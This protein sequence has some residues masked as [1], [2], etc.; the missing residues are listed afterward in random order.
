M[1]DLRPDDTQNSQRSESDERA[2]LPP[3]LLPIHDRLSGDGARWRWRAPTGAG[4]GDWA[5]ATLAEAPEE[6]PQLQLRE[7]RLGT[8]DADRST[9]HLSHGPKG[10]MRDMHTTSRMRGYLGAAAAV[11]V[12]GLIALLLTQGLAHRGTGANG[13]A[14]D[15]TATVP[16][17]PGP[18]GTPGSQPPS[19]YVQ[20]DQLPVVAAN[21]SSVVYKIAGGA[22][23]RSS[24]G[25]KTYGSAALPR[26]D[27]SQIDSMSIAV[28]PLDAN[29][30][31]VTLGGQK[32][33]QGCAPP[34]NPYPALA[35]HGGVMA[36][37]YVPCAEQYMSVDGGH[38]WTQPKLPT[39][40]VIGGLNM[41]RSV[42]GAYGD[43]SYVFQTQ[44]Q[45][46]YAAMAFDDMGGS[47]ID[48]PGVRLI[49][50][51]D[52]GATWRFVDGGL[53]TSNHFVCDFAASP[54]PSTVYAVTADSSGCNNE[55][56]PSLSLYRSDN[57]G[58]SWSRVRSLPQQAE[59][60][61]FVGAHGEL[62]TYLPQVTVQGH[63]ASV[64]NSPADAVVSVDGGHTFISAPSAGLPQGANLIG[65]F[66]TLADGSVVY[67]EYGPQAVAGP[68]T[69]YTWKQGQSAWTQ[70]TGTL[71]VAVAAVVVA[72]THDPAA[73]TKTI[74]ILIDANGNV[75][76][77][78]VPVP[79]AG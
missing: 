10:P 77:M 72:Q 40:G 15:A 1:S 49:A 57:G 6:S 36:S 39:K 58:Q 37:G 51:D 2:S 12:V 43:Q 4:L 9:R 79:I 46:L 55:G 41:M 32:S 24:D 65:P 34:N 52:G 29:H 67:G 42:Q 68:L 78:P 45:R 33:G 71:H 63:G 22:L 27:L 18:T 70:Y 53:A 28:S 60:G 17:T 38:T 7:R 14:G 47:L 19:S 74:T 11:V 25:G 48:S 64:A 61:L 13:G 50:S 75:I 73:T 76:P 69:L 16:P 35:T 30:I 3:D 23:Q 21:D 8:L 66:A 62:Y 5:R 54:I 59:T 20:P 44:G 26:T 31:F 56:Y